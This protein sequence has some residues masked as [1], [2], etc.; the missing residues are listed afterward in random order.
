MASTVPDDL[1]QLLTVVRFEFLRYSRSFRLPA[2]VV[3]VLV[4][5][6]LSIGIPLATGNELG[7]DA[8]GAAQSLLSLITFMITI[9]VTLFA[10]D[11]ICSEFEKRTG[12]FILPNPV[13]RE[14]V[15]FG[16]FIASLLAASAAMALYYL[17]TAVTVAVIFGTVPVALGISFGFCLLYLAAVCAL[18][19]AISAV[20]KSSLASILLV[21]LLLFMIFPII[22]GV[23]SIVQFKP[24]FSI[25]FQGGVLTTVLQDPYPT[26]FAQT[27]G[28]GGGGG[29]PGGGGN[30]TS[31]MTIYNYYPTPLSAAAVMVAYL[32]VFTALGLMMFK[33]R[34]L[35]T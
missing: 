15:F 22:D 24:S 34:E 31:A 11:S 19:Y 14:T 25:S 18:A 10:S 20:L 9:A 33:R 2:V 28:M 6:G 30:S 1:T 5:L 16:K 32:V 4:V 8:S 7:Q 17:I 29:G 13:R 23:G 21:F 35:T 26:D 27:F 12:Y 3:I